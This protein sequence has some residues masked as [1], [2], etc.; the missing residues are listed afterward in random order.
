MIYLW[1]TSLH[2][3]TQQWYQYKHWYWHNIFMASFVLITKHYTGTSMAPLIAPILVQHFMAEIKCI[4][5][6]QHFR[7]QHCFH[8]QT[9]QRSIFNPTQN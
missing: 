9:Q 5:I 7:G 4:N 6:A 2:N 3:W 1:Q 8:N